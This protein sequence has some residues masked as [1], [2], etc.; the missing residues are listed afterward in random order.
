MFDSQLVG[1]LGRIRRCGLVGVGVGEDAP[2]GG[3]VV[4]VGVMYCFVLF[5]LLRLQNLLHQDQS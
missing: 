3:R 2:L 4:F 5:C 1:Y